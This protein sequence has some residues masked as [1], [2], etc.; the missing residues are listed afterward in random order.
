[1][2]RSKYEDRPVLRDMDSTTV[3]EC[4]HI[5]HGNIT[6]YIPSDEFQEV[7]ISTISSLWANGYEIIIRGR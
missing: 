3:V 5:Y 1:M 7:F 2:M 6:L 4:L